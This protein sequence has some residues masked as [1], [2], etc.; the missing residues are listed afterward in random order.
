MSDMTPVESAEH[1]CLGGWLHRQ[2]MVGASPG[3]VLGNVAPRAGIR[4]G[5]SF[6]LS[7]PRNRRVGSGRAGEKEDGAGGAMPADPG[8]VRA[9]HGA[10]EAATGSVGL[11]CNPVDQ[12]FEVVD[13]RFEHPDRAAPEI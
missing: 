10:R 4:P 1:I 8:Q 3:L 12:R 9:K 11:A 6:R 5:P 7:L 2:I 13:A